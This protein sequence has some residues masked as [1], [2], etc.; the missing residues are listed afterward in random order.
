MDMQR[1][2]SRVCLENGA[3]QLSW[4]EGKSENQRTG[5]GGEGLGPGEGPEER[6]VA[7]S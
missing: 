1:H 3:G 7:F 6:R 4:R 2:E 5:M